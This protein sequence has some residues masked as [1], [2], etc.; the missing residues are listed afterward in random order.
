M[1][2]LL[3]LHA[4]EGTPGSDSHFDHVDKLTSGLNLQELVLRKGSRSFEMWKKPPIPLNFDVYLFNW[5]NPTNLS[6]ADYEKP[7]VEQIGPFRFREKTDKT[8]IR[9]HPK[10]R[11]ISYRRRSYYYFVEEESVGRL[12]DKITTLNAVALV[13]LHHREADFV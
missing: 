10:N 9:F 13:G 6:S 2:G 3:S 5:T 8:D 12:D 7:V 1:D 11:T 4:L